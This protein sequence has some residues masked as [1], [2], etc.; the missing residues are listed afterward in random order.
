[1]SN[2]P[3]GACENNFS[4]GCF[5][6]CVSV[7]TG[8]TSAEAGVHTI[9]YNLLGTIHVTTVSVEAPGLNILIPANFF[10]EDGEAYFTI[11]NPSG[12]AYS[13]AFEGT[14]YTCF[15]AKM[16]ITF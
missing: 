2:T 3:C 1:M 13:H 5:G 4:V 15:K 8:L 16:Q 14:N 9:N 6:H 10:N 12:S 11:T 7:N